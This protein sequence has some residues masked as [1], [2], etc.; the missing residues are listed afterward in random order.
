M[1]LFVIIFVLTFCVSLH[2]ESQNI[3]L[4]IKTEKKGQSVLDS[5][6]NKTSFKNMKVLFEELENITKG[7]YKSGYIEARLIDQKKINDTVY[8]V[9]YDLKTKYEDIYI[10]DYKR[11]ISREV[12]SEKVTRVEE[13]FFII[14][15]SQIENILNHINAYNGDNGYPFSKVSLSEIYK[16]N[17]NL[18]AASLIVDNESSQRKID[19]II[20]KGYEKF[21]KSYLKYFIGLKKNKLL[22]LNDLE[23]TTQ[24]FNTLRFVS[25]IKPPE[26]LFTKDSTAVYLYLK[27]LQNNSFDGFLGFGTNEETNKLQFDGYLNLSLNNNLNYGE[28]LNLSYKSDE[29]EQRQIFLNLILPYILKSP[30]GVNLSLDLFKRDSTFTTTNQQIN[31]FYPFK[32]KFNIEAGYTSLQ[33]NVLSNSFNESLENFNSY[34]FSSSLSYTNFNTKNI[35]FPLKTYAFLR[36][37]FGQRKSESTNENQFKIGATFSKNIYLN[38]KNIIYVKFKGDYLKSDTY[39]ENELFRFGGINSIRGFEENTLIASAVGVLNTEYRYVASKNLYL[40]TI[41]DA[42]Y[43]ENP[44]L[45]SNEKLFGIGFGFGLLTDAGLIQLNYATAKAE[46][47]KFDLKNSKLHVSLKAIF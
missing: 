32:S 35:L 42:A 39:F 44:A 12:I 5:L 2:C 47:Q 3:T 38:A 26:L 41:F 30:V 24:A 17:K 27:K 6:H 20:I 34:F 14:K 21:P 31:V 37:G 8:Q 46:N 9:L 7:L 10:Y 25:E 18:L 28:S 29:N 43:F 33:S 36:F 4:V 1:R 19:N 22:S 23:Q 13:N 40:H 45:N 15:I 16:R 11:Y